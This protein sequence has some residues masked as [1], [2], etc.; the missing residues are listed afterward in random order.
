MISHGNLLV[1]KRSISKRIIKLT[2][3]KDIYIGYLPLA[4]V[5]ELL[6]EVYKYLFFLF[7]IKSITWTFFLISLKLSLISMGIMIGFSSPQTLTDAS[8]SIK[9]GQCGDLKILNPSL[10]H[11]VPA[12]LE[13]FAKAVNLKLAN[14]SWLK[15]KLFDIASK[16]KL[17]FVKARRNTFLLDKIVFKK[18]SEAVVGRNL[19]IILSGGSLLNESVHEF[20]QVIIFF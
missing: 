4:H 15:K 18:I 12:V 17:K 5:L 19:R 7:V 1:A 2:P 8:T 11:A 14:A 10:M 16:Q 13:R 20:I 6:S 9:K 3:G